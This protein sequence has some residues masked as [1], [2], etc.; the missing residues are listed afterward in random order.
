MV[1]KKTKAKARV[2]ATRGVEEKILLVL[3]NSNYADEFDIQGFALYKNDVWKEYL[4]EVKTKVF[5]VDRDS[6][7]ESGPHVAS[8]GTNEQIG[9]EDF[10]S[11]KESFKTITVTSEEAKRLGT[12]FGIKINKYFDLEELSSYGVFL[13]LDLSECE[14]EEEVEEDEFEDDEN[15]DEDEEEDDEDEDE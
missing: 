15:E 6:T 14:E 9:F 3:C 7:D 8:L 2:V 4:K 1:K 10:D 13:A 12:L 11:Y 5:N